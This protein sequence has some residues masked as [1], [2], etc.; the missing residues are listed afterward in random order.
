MT[1]PFI[2]VCEWAHWEHNKPSL[3]RILLA[4]SL[5]RSILSAHMVHYPVLNHLD[6]EFNN[7]VQCKT[8]R[9]KDKTSNIFNQLQNSWDT[10]PFFVNFWISHPQV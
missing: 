2:P 10:W 9:N 1:V 6:K 5:D 4:S 7:E 8:F 3:R